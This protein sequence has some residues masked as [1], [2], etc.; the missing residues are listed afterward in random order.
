MGCKRMDTVTYP[1]KAVIQY[2]QENM[3][4]VKILHDQQPLADRFHVKWTP[5]LVI[6][7]DQDNEVYHGEGFLGPRDLIPA[8]M[9]GTGKVHLAAG[10]YKEAAESF[11][12][13]AS[14]FPKSDEAAEALYFE[15]VTRFKMT[16]DKNALTEMYRK[17]SARF[18]HSSW[19]R[20][21]EP[22]R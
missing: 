20:K 11:D 4:P 14:K 8:L 6:L 21:A 1:N 17:L 5:T 10:Q 3:I 12:H 2:V 13:L 19:T 18:P 22:Y 7:G 15:G 9:L 16:K